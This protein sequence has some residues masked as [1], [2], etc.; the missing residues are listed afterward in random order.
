VRVVFA[1][2]RFPE[3]VEGLLG[4]A[5]GRDALRAR[6]PWRVAL[7][8]ERALPSA[9]VGPRDFAPLVREALI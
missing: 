4:F 5:I 7:G 8:A 9:V 2:E 3:Q 6:S 1:D